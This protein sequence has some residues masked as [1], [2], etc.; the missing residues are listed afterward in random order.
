MY[1]DRKNHTAQ[2]ISHCFVLG[3]GLN[4]NVQI[5]SCFVTLCLSF[6]EE[7][8]EVKEE[9]LGWKIMDFWFQ[10]FHCPSANPLD[11]KL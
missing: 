2:L 4:S 1:K 3:H 7:G 9:E 11:V 5:Q 6:R 10:P 8:G